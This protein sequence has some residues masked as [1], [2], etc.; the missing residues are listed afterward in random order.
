MTEGTTTAAAESGDTL[1]RLE[2]EGEIAADYLE[3][4]LDIADLDGDIDM[5]VEADRAAVSIVSDS[6]GRDLQK[7]V[8]RD[9]E[10]LEALQELTRLAV[11]RET[12]DRSRLMLDI[13]GFRAKK[14]EELAALGAKAA[15]DVKSS[16]EPL[17]LAP[18]TPFER[19]V[20][21]DAVAAA[22]LKSESE[23]EEPQRF[24]VVLPA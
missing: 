13:A 18:M 7:L 6:A 14:R 20:V 4:L 24:V 16:G 1:T 10:V 11:H 5:D 9:G 19:K 8:G 23:G 17:K 21:H 22:G 2:Q 12:G 15:E 3:G